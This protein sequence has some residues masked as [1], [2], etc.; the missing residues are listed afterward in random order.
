MK[1]SSFLLASLLFIPLTAD[2]GNDCEYI[3]SWFGYDAG[4]TIAWM[5][6]SSGKSSS[7]GTMLLELPGFDMTFGGFFPD[8]NKSTTTL[9][10]TWQRTGGRT[11]SYATM[12]FATND[13][14]IPIWAG[15]LTGDLT[16]SEDCNMLVVD[17][18]WLSVYI[19]DMETD[20]VPIWHKTPELGP[21]P[22]EPHAGYRVPL[23]LP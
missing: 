10:G 23:D 7:S 17:N 16:I 20:P 19:V 9:K 18:T 11:F 1:H 4:E 8:A 12:G 22:F 14:G 2:A 3:G 6:Q 15:R 21:M 13:V 5:A